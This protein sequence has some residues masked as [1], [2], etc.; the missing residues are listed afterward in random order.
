MPNKTALE[1]LDEYGLD[2]DAAADALVH[3][4]FDHTGVIEILCTAIDNAGS[5]EDFEE[6][7]KLNFPRKEPSSQR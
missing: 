6:F 4:W 3:G 5:L 2:D 7:L 1:L